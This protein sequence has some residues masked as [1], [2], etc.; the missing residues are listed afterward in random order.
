VLALIP[1]NLDG[2][3]FEWATGKASHTLT[4][5]AADFTGWR[6]DASKFDGQVEKII[7]ALRADDGRLSLQ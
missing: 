6:Q 4:R 1:L 3:L 2:Y 5:F 7:E